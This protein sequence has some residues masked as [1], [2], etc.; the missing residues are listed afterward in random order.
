MK[1]RMLSLETSSFRLQTRLCEVD[2][3][4]DSNSILP[5]NIATLTQPLGQKLS[6]QETSDTFVCDSDIGPQLEAVDWP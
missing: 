5:E 2:L 6:H 3:G 1:S 4:R